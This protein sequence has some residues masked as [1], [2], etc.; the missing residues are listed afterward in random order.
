L[1][2]HKFNI[3]AHCHPRVLLSGIPLLN[4]W[5]RGIPAQKHAGMTIFKKIIFLFGFLISSP[6]F[7]A[8]IFQEKL[9]LLI[10]TNP[11]QKFEVLTPVGATMKNVEDA[12]L[13]LLRE[14]KKVEADAVMHVICTPPGI[15]RDG[16]NWA[17]EQAY[18]RGKAIR[19]LKTKEVGK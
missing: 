14:A 19:F 13:Q 6:V 18:C 9:P 4:N 12:K 7:S 10:E 3:L 11:S 17:H 5:K 8:E 15:R 1:N 2:G 16:L